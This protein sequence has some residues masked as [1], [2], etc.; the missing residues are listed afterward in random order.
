MD[1]IRTPKTVMIELLAM[2][3]AKRA[4]LK[5][6]DGIEQVAK[7]YL[8]KAIEDAD[9]AMLKYIIDLIE[10]GSDGGEGTPQSTKKKLDR[11]LEAAEGAIDG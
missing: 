2:P 1:K 8:D 7:V 5:P 3:L 10:K 9:G 4:S 6:S 11:F